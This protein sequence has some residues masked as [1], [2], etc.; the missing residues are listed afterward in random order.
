[1]REHDLPE[2][3]A[4]ELFRTMSEESFAELMHAAYLQTFPTQVQLIS[5]GDLADFLFILLEG[6]VELLGSTAGRETTMAIIKPFGTFILAAVLMD[7]I[8]LMSAR[9]TEK[10]RVLMI[11]ARNIR[12]LLAKDG[13]FARAIVVELSSCYRAVVRDQ[14]NLKLRSS[15]ERLANRIISLHNAQGATGT[16][17]LP[18]DKKT[19]A[20]LLNMTPENLSRAFGTLKAYGVQVDNERIC[21]SDLTSLET[22]AQP[23]RLIDERV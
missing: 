10:S 7:A 2:I 15:V 13:D 14:K 17:I 8:H 19:L 4:L 11:P 23:N 12:D 3:R 6:R 9:T 22:L 20:S 18:Y 16:V 21:L 1:M 5:E